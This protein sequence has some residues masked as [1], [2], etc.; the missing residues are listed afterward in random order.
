MPGWGDFF[1]GLGQIFGKIPIQ[2][3]RERWRNELEK[4]MM[5]RSSLL[6][7]VCD[8]KKADRLAWISNRVN[9]LNGLLKNAERD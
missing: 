9:V 1:G 8:D 4:L 5:E 2:G 3:R 7:G 6:Q